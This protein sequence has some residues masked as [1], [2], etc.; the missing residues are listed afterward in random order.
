MKIYKKK[1]NHQFI[2]L[3]PR[4]L[5]PHEILDCRFPVI[6]NDLDEKTRKISVPCF[7]HCY[8]YQNKLFF[9]F[10]RLLV[11]KI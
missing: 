9:S 1:K 11:V 8:W 5:F 4:F 3:N 2:N 7:Y 10:I 6:F